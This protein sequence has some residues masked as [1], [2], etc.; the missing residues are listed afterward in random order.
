MTAAS[1]ALSATLHHATFATWATAWVDAGVLG[2]GDVH[3]A[4]RLGLLLGEPHREVLL[5]AAFAVRAPRQG[6][7]GYAP[8]PRPPA[9]P[10]GDRLAPPLPWPADLDAWRAAIA[11]S[12]LVGPDVDAQR[13]FV[14]DGEMLQLHRLALYEH[15]LAADLT[16]RATYLP[17][18]DVDVATLTADLAQLFPAQPQSTAPDLQ[19]LAAAMA[20]LSRTTVISGGPGTGK[21]TTIL[22][23]LVALKRQAAALGRETPRVALAAPT[24]KA[25]A[26][27]REALLEGSQPKADGSGAPVSDLVQAERPWLESLQARTLHKLLGWRPA[28][29]SRFV[30]NRENPLPYD[31]I[32]V[33]EASMIDLAMMAK[34][35]QAVPVDGRLVLLGDRN[36]LASVDAGCALG[37]ITSG[38]GAQGIRLSPAAAARLAEAV[39]TALVEPCVVAEA[40]ELSGGMVHLLKA[41]RFK[42]P[43]LGRAITQVALASNTDDERV[44]SAAI[45]E[46]LAVLTAQADGIALVPHVGPIDRPQWAPEPLGDVVTKFTEALRPL[47]TA[48]DDAT[49]AT[50]LRALDGVRVLTAHRQGDLGVRGLNETLTLAIQGRLKPKKSGVWWTGRVVLVTANDAEQG[51]WNGDVGV[52]LWDESG[53]QVAF[54]G[55]SGPRRIGVAA[56]PE[57]ETAFAMTI[58]KSQGSQFAHVCLVLPAALSPIMTREL[59]Y[60]G[61]SRASQTLTLCGSADIVRQALQVRVQ[62]A[63]RLGPL[64]WPAGA[65]V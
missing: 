55:P 27:M 19:K 30:H 24:G 4:E 11:H 63:T 12:P 21:T 57:H 15:R 60:T 10:D 17:P 64:L 61:I 28:T 18:H 7:T 25:A 1:T 41:H 20:V 32:V 3:V 38:T 39:G 29:P 9:V 45:D 49:L 59:V 31:V 43:Q 13:P 52:A 34:L 36:Q 46:A 14:W 2:L 35:V 42:N 44:R 48:T 22:R 53:W 16:A 37:D 54:A 50:V 58:H 23:V 6:H 26:R 5:A 8:L 62:R 65:S 56:L 51:L 47:K 33:D 40:S